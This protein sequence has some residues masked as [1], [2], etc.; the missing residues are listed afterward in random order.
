VSSLIS[1]SDLY[2]NDYEEFSNDEFEEDDDELNSSN[3]DTTN[4][5]Q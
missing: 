3:F 2:A 4:E 5:F 1:A